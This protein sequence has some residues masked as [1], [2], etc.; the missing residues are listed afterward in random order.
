MEGLHSRRRSG[1]LDL[2]AQLTANGLVGT[3]NAR[4]RLV[5]LSADA[6]EAHLV[7][8]D[9]PEHLTMHLGAAVGAT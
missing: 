3:L 5:P 9:T 4:R 1:V 2:S 8:D 6:A 7:R